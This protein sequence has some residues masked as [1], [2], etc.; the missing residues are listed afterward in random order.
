MIPKQTRLLLI[1]PLYKCKNSF[2][3]IPTIYNDHLVNQTIA[4]TQRLDSLHKY[5]TQLNVILSAE[6]EEQ[7]QKV[8]EKVS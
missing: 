7:R 6:S 1:R 3:Y 2:I 5:S 4:A 8:T